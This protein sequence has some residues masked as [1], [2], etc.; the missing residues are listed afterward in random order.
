MVLNSFLILLQEI[1][2][3]G[4]Q[5]YTETNLDNLIAEPFNAVSAFIFLG[6]AFYW[7]IRLKGR[8]KEYLFL[9]LALPILL[10]GGFGGTMYHAF[11]IS[12][13]FLVMDWMPILILCL[14]ASIYFFVRGGG[15]WI[16]GVGA[17][18]ALFLLQWMAG[19][20]VPEAYRL[21]VGYGIMASLIL[22]PIL[23]VIKKTNFHQAKWVG[24]GLGA[25]LFAIFFRAVDPLAWIPMGTHFLWHVFGAIACHSLLT[26][27]YELE[28]AKHLFAKKD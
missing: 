24:L 9:S 23:M 13:V 15:G 14:S 8:Y 5:R 4:G 3:D 26:Y 16:S 17:V 21:N 10:I 6:I 27:I 1:L 25:F 7:V 28:S 20:W 12:Q 22:I 18:V 2:R 11:R 19:Q